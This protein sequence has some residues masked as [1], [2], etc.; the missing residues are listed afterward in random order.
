MDDHI[1]IHLN[2]PAVDEHTLH[3]VGAA[4]VVQWHQLS[5]EARNLILETVG[6]PICANFRT[7][8][9]VIRKFEEILHNNDQV[10]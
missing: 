3:S 9:D 6:K 7:P 2:D 4:V 8:K 5:P 10:V 1:Y